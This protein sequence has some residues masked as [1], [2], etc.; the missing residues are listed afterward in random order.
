[1]L[2]NKLLPC[3]LAVVLMVG[4]T[5]II[6]AVGTG[7]IKGTI[8]DKET[9]EGIIG[10]SVMVIGTHFGAMTDPEGKYVIRRLQPGIYTLKVAHLDFNIVEV[11]QIEVKPNMTIEVSA[12]LEKKLTTIG[13]TI[14]VRAEDDLIS[15]LETSDRVTII[16]EKITTPRPVTSVDE[17][18]AQVAGV[19][20]NKDGEIFIRGSRSGE[21]ANIAKGDPTGDPAGGQADRRESVAEAEQG[22]Q[23]GLNLCAP[24]T[25][26]ST[27]TQ[28]LIRTPRGPQQPTPQPRCGTGYYPP[29]HDESDY[30]DGPPFDAMFFQNYGTN[31]FVNT[32]SDPLS[33]FA[34]DVDDA[35]YTLTRSY[36]ERGHL[37]PSDAV[38]VEEFVNRFEYDYHQPKTGEA[39]SI[40]MEGAPSRFGD[41][42]RMLRIGIGG[43]EFDEESRKPA[44]LVFVI[45][46]S[47][48]M[49]RENRLSMVKHSLELLVNQL[50]WG[51]RVGIVTYGSTG[52]AVLQPTI[53]RHRKQIINQIQMLF[54]GGSTYA[55]QG[56]RLG[57]QMANGM[58]DPKRTNRVILCSD[59][60][61]N[62]GQTGPDELVKMIKRCADQGITLTTVGFGMG[63]YNDVLMEKLADNGNGQYA[64]IDDMDEARRLFVD[65]L[66]G[67][68]QVIARDVKIQVDFNPEVVSSYRLLGY[69]N[70]DVADHKFRD[71]REDGGEIGAGHQVTALYEVNL[72]THRRAVDLGSV[73]IRYKNP[74]M[75]EVTE[76]RT[77]IRY[78]VFH[79]QFKNASDDFKLA[80]ASAEFSEILRE[81]YWAR[82]SSLSSVRAVLD[83]IDGNDKQ[84]AE[85]KNL[86]DMARRHGDIL[87]ER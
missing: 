63:N 65:K 20:T 73:Y 34:I 1:M 21:V 61:A 72:I 71:N 42:C 77:P 28:K 81:S 80:A 51:D 41:D 79:K 29:G 53:V 66:S 2:R 46:V 14:T 76:V 74:Q 58:F 16:K 31:S 60:V 57:Y 23:V 22:S 25:P 32:D 45:D 55:E 68:L 86:I 33:T 85:L 59:G 54:P 27:T 70:R 78:N 35:S 7:Q 5:V 24:V 6:N 67:T 87:A 64:Y 62:V 13:Q 10:A 3:L 8:T 26:Q 43:R 48:S 47:G 9:G 36:L 69:E 11:T 50:T 17:L 4:S 15:K 75:D 82:G 39:F 84:I 38:R 52:N 12:K 40:Q 37:P 83:E 44:N 19:V 49:G 56:I 30:L 18:L